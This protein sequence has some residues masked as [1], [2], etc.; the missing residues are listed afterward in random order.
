MDT[1]V[2]GAGERANHLAELLRYRELLYMLTYRDIRIRYKQ[3]LMGFFWAIMMPCVIV[4]A[5]VVVKYGFSVV[6]GVPLQT[7]DLTSVAVRA[8]P[9]A[10]TVSALRFAT[11]SLALNENLV[12]KIYFPKEVIPISAVLASA[13]DASIAAAAL[14]VMLVIFG[15]AGGWTL[16]WVPVLVVILVALVSGAALLFSAAGL[17]FRDVKFLVE[18]MLTFGIFFTPVFY[19]VEMF[20]E[21]GVWFMLNPIAPIVEAL[22][23]AVIAGQQPNLAWLGYSA[24]FAMALC[25]GGYWFFKRVEP[26]FAE[27]I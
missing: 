14:T 18:I 23:A 11:N 25:I 7:A 4:L 12:T 15:F 2:S 22:D 8:L 3:S 19:K 16:L 9:W 24:L 13:F 27:V 1:I 26:L 20:G 21:H 17:F 6:S 10:F 5:G